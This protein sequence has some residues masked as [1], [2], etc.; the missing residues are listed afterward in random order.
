MNNKL[1]FVR[2]ILIIGAVLDALFVPPLIIPSLAGMVIGV[3]SF[4]PDAASLYLMHVAAALMAGWMGVLFWTAIKPVERRGIIPITLFP[5]LSG[6]AAAGIYFYQSGGISLGRTIA[7]VSISMV[8][9]I[10]QFIGYLFTKEAIIVHSQPN[11]K[12]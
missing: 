11:E 1:L 4:K 10:A 2:S 3:K 7:L 6:L 9:F 5:L 12:H 8:L